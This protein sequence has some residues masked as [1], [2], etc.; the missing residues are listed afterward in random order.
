MMTGY[1]YHRNYALQASS[2]D[3][4]GPTLHPT[5]LD[6]TVH[7]CQP[8]KIILLVAC[9][10]AL[11]ILALSILVLSILILFILALVTLA[12]PS[13]TSPSQACPFRALSSLVLFSPSS[14]PRWRRLFQASICSRERTYPRSRMDLNP[15]LLARPNSRL[16]LRA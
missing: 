3:G 11:S 6:Q 13:L 8:S 9:S 2:A 16:H 15:R 10:L 1:I 7:L 14:T 12:L 5:D 4:R